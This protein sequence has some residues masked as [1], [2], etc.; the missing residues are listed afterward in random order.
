MADETKT[1]D[2]PGTNG[3]DPNAT[4]NTPPD[5][6]PDTKAKA[7]EKTAGPTKVPVPPGM[8]GVLYAGQFY[9]ADEDG[10]VEVP[11]EALPHLESQAMR[12]EAREDSRLRREEELQVTVVG[13]APKA[14]RG[15]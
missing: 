13:D 6:K 8:T 10:E 7:K 2:G 15:R 9:P 11:A 1:N 4:T 3:P 5:A 12:R 14:R